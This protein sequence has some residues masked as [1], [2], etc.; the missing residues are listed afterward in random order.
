MEHLSEEFWTQRYRSQQ[1]GWDIG[2]IST[3]IREYIDQLK[4][5][6]MRILIPG[7]GSGYEAE[8]LH[9]KGFSDVRILDFSAEPLQMFTQRVPDFP[10]T[11]IH[12]ADFFSFAGEF[13]LILEQTLFCAIHPSLRDDYARQSASLL[14][15]GGKLVG[16]LFDTEFEGGPPYGGCKEEYLTY[17][18]KYFSEVSMEACHNSIAPRAGR[19]LFIRLTK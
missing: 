14:R 11:H 7:C 15:S 17:F 19:E 12:Q 2:D 18:Q 13:D 9:A 10:G 6:S 4:G 16:L 5:N 8:Y 1:T 3:P